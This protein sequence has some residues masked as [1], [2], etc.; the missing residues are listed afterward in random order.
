MVLFNA[1]TEDTYKD[2]VINNLDYQTLFIYSLKDKKLKQI[3]FENADVT[4]MN[5]VG[6]SKDLIISFGV[7]HNKDGK[8][9]AYTEPSLIK[10]YDYAK[11][12]LTD[13]VS[14]KINAELQKQ[15]DGTK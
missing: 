9:D 7:D 8:F 15:L 2:G 5:F 3:K 10:K 11:G 1:S 14:K 4:Q 6:S 12:E 13:I